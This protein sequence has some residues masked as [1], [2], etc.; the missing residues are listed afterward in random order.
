MGMVEYLG[1]DELVLPTLPLHLIFHLLHDLTIDLQYIP[2]SERISAVW[3][4]ERPIPNFVT[5]KARKRD[6]DS[7]DQGTNPH[8]DIRDTIPDRGQQKLSD[9][10]PKNRREPNDVL[11]SQSGKPKL[12]TTIQPT[13]VTSN[14][15]RNLSQICQ[16]QSPTITNDDVRPC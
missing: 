15:S 14:V 1:A 6:K 12:E 11:P 4:K 8:L 10:C 3:P 16:T 5:K 2:V 9:V 13:L 7:L